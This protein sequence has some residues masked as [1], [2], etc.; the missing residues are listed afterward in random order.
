MVVNVLEKI[1][2]YLFPYENIEFHSKII[3]YG[4]GKVGQC[5][6]QQVAQ[7]GYCEVICV[8]DQEYEQYPA[9]GV[10]LYS[11]DTI[12]NSEYDKILIAVN[13]D[14][15]V[16]EIKKS[17]IEKYSVD[18]TKIVC[19]HGRKFVPKYHEKINIEQTG[20]GE[21]AYKKKEISMAFYLGGG[22]G[23]CIIAKRLIEE[24]TSMAEENCLVDIYGHSKNLQY[25]KTI[26]QGCHYINSIFIGTDLYKK[27]CKNYV[28][29]MQISY[30][31]SID[32][33]NFSLM[34]SNNEEL[35]KRLIALQKEVKKYGLDTTRGTDNAIHFAQ[36]K[37]KR[38]NCYTANNYDGILAIENNRVN[39]PLVSQ[40]L[41]VFQALGLN[42]YI[43]LNYGWGENSRGKNRPPNKIWPAVYYEQLI[44]LFKLKFPQVKVVQL[45]LTSSYNIKGVDRYVLGESIELTK[46][47]LQNSLLHID[48]EGGLVHL[49][50]QLGTK[51]VVL[52]GPT[53]VHYF[54]YKENINIVADVCKECY[55]L[56]ND[57]SKCIRNLEKPECMYSLMPD[58]VMEKV[59]KYLNGVMKVQEK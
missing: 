32:S 24:F 29:A 27:E 52:F 54:G 14:Y 16:E 43:T 33:L 39:I 5:Y 15:L 30:F 28:L 56:D 7:T 10:P 49:A 11:P 3:I 45:G 40:Y 13:A 18:R 17:L 37:Y 23:D 53:P 42:N 58:M 46:Y 12:I 25:V 47:I 41:A 50:T 22:L 19:G 34:Q 57:F 51:C 21:P 55:Y 59:E 38:N 31:L 26:F 44:Q 1:P 35:A 8:V 20:Y 9:L 4:A 6:L 36:S 2:L 48:C